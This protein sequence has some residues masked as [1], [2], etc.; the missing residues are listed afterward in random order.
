MFKQS[1]TAGELV[2]WL[3]MTGTLGEVSFSYYVA[4]RL[5]AE[6][7]HPI[8]IHSC[9]ITCPST[10][11]ASGSGQYRSTRSWCAP[12]LKSPM[13]A[14]PIRTHRSPDTFFGPTEK[15]AVPKNDPFPDLRDPNDLGNP[16]VA[17]PLQAISG[18][19][20]EPLGLPTSKIIVGACASPLIPLRRA[21][22][23]RH[24]TSSRSPSLIFYLRE[25]RGSAVRCS[26]IVKLTRLAHP[27]RQIPL[28]SVG[29]L[30]GKRT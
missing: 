10:V 18:R 11:C 1:V 5:M 20:Y 17:L 23:S 22:S 30:G 7:Q 13:A 4:V 3:E 2:R 24:R 29:A 6:S 16:P 12:V 9:G 25:D 14:R 19:S 26:L 8:A 27:I 21:L 28:P 15:G